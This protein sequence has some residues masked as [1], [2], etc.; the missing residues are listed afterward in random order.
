M[1]QNKIIAAYVR[2]S[3][4]DYV[5]MLKQAELAIRSLLDEETFNAC[6]F[7]MYIDFGYLGTTKSRPAFEELLQDMNNGIVESVIV[8]DME[9]LSRD[10]AIYEEIIHIARENDVEVTS[11]S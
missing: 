9:R 6:K 3:T 4:T 7:T 5:P 11:L 1:D 2:T 8:A 10:A